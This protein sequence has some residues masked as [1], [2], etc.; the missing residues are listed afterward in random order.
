M[1]IRVLVTVKAYPSIGKTIGESVCVA[2]IDLE[3]RGWVRLYPLPFRELPDEQQFKKFA[4]VEIDVRKPR[5]DPR[6]ESRRCDVDSVRVV[7]EALPAGVAKKRREAVLPLLQP[8]MCAIQRQQRAAGTSLGVF[9]PKELLD[10]VATGTDEAWA[11]EKQARMDQTKLLGRDLPPL[12]KIPF[13]FAYRYL[14]DDAKCRGHR[15]TI[16]DWEI[17]EAFRKWRRVYGEARALTMIEDKWAGEMWSPDRDTFLFAGNQKLHP[18]SFLLLGT[19]WPKKPARGA[20][21]S[22]WVQDELLP[23]R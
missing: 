14:C 1:R 5:S 9:R 7:E 10:F 23:P 21:P 18:Q 16:I 8:S 17:M 11:P 15:Q 19:F 20:A 2:G 13:K 12:E 6:P 3:S 4:T 22:G